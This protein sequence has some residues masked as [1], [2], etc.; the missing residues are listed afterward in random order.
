M[1]TRWVRRSAF[2]LIELLVVI[3]I[4]AILIGLLLPAVQKVR[5][6]AAR[7]KCTN[8]L[9]QL[10]LACHNYASSNGSLPPGSDVRFN[11][12]HPR[13]LTYIEQDAMFKTYDLNGQFG[14]LA[15]SWFASV[16]AYNIPQAASTP[17][18]G[19]WGL[20]LPDLSVFV[21]PS[22]V[23]RSTM[24]YLVQ[25]T[26]VGYGDI[27][28]RGSLFG[29]TST[30]PVA[31]NYYIYDIGGSVYVINNTGYTSYLFNRGYCTNDAKDG[32]PPSPDGS[33]WPGPFKYTKLTSAATQYSTQGT[34]TS[35]GNAIESIGDG[36]SNTICFEE[37]NGG[38][39]N[40]QGPQGWTEMN[41]GHAPFYA[42]FGNC[43]DHTN[44]NCDFAHGGF[45]WGIPSSQHAG[46]QIMTAFCD[47]SVRGLS[48]TIDYTTWV[49][50]CGANDGK[51]VTFQ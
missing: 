23:D 44:P 18:Q 31:Y 25:V 1:V 4:I 32:S 8:N 33:P 14:P 49:Y 29:T 2:T 15:S 48:P 7:T 24:A 42:D 39:L 35:L 36:T 9:K 22:A 12:I 38:W 50:M 26:Q 6:A 19:R 20:F 3:A 11:G 51:N 28:Y 17:T 13:L 45:G 40:F 46:N 43:P 21:C 10:A 41:W 16:N 34:P 37:S 30:S 27:D 5:E 47:G